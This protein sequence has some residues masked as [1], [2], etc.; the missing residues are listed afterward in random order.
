MAGLLGSA[1]AAG[2]GSLGEMLMRQSADDDA[3]Q[4]K[5]KLQQEAIRQKGEEAR[6]LAEQKADNN[7]SSKGGRANFDD[8]NQKMSMALSLGVTVPELDQFLGHMRGGDEP[9][10]FYDRHKYDPNAPLEDGT[11]ASIQGAV[12]SGSL[13]AA[14][15]TQQDAVDYQQASPHLNAEQQQAQ[16]AQ[17]GYDAWM[18][19]MREGLSNTAD[20]FNFGGGD[21]KAQQEAIGLQQK[22]LMR[23]QVVRGKMPLDTFGAIYAADDGTIPSFEAQKVQQAG[24][25][26]SARVQNLEARTDATQ[27][28][29]AGLEQRSSIAAQRL[30]IAKRE[31]DRRDYQAQVDLL[32]QLQRSQADALKLPYEKRKQA[33]DDATKKVAYQQ[34]IVDDMQKRGA[35]PINSTPSAQK[36]NSAADLLH[37]MK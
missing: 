15:M 37:G 32:K 4:Q 1:L 2:L 29:A 23:E 21:L 8:P 24:L 16:S 7:A 33:Y 35:A 3:Y 30:E 10:Q 19:K 26:G 22:N 9:V 18:K 17:L 14:A 13:P 36:L 34:A 11:G 28:Q 12:N 6:M 20:M 5:L 27:K 25:L 31:Q